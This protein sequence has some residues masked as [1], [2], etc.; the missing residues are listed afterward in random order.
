MKFISIYDCDCVEWSDE[1]TPKKLK[2]PNIFS[3][4]NV[5]KKL[6][7]NIEDKVVVLPKSG[8]AVL[9]KATI[10]KTQIKFRY[11][12]ENVI[13]L[14]TLE[15]EKEQIN[16]FKPPSIIL[17]NAVFVDKR[18]S[19]NY[20][21]F[22][23]EILPRIFL[24][25]QENPQLFPS[26]PVILRKGASSLVNKIFPAYG[27]SDLNVLY[28]VKETTVFVEKLYYPVRNTFHP[29]RHSFKAI[30]AV[31]SVIN[32]VAPST[33]AKRKIFLSRNDASNRK[34]LNHQEVYNLLKGY[35]FEFIEPGKLSFEEQVEVFS[36]A[37]VVVGAHGAAL[38]NIV[39]MPLKSK[40]VMLAPP[41]AGGFFFRSLCSHL[42][43]D[44]SVVFGCC[45]SSSNHDSDYQINIYDLASALSSIDMS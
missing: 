9:D 16:S 19:S 23:L 36:S 39:F 26:V 35:G 11:F 1:A 31:R 30:E 13:L 2:R 42:E 6:L 32:K 21:H 29:D 45:V 24:F 41:A 34:L 14:E 5:S 22:L 17:K 3:S 25:K 44:F 28:L 20:G 7:R 4:E 33:K 27:M 8:T 37:S 43:H 38:T 18:S 12:N 40:V 10:C 15:S